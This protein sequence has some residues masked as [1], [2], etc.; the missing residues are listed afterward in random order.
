MVYQHGNIP[1]KTW[2]RLLAAREFGTYGFCIVDSF[3]Y[4]KIFLHVST[5]SINH[6]NSSEQS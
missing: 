1:H 4:T 2:T 5:F 3:Y 6:N